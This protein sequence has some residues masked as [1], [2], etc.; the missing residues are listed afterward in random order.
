MFGIRVSVEPVDGDDD[1]DTV[2]SQVL[3]VSHQIG[4]SLLH[5]IDVFLKVLLA[6]GLARDHLRRFAAV[7]LQSAHRADQ[8]G[9]IRLQATVV[10]LDVEE[11]LATHIGTEASLGKHV[12]FLS[13]QLQSQLV[14]DDRGIAVRNVGEG[15]GVNQ[16]RSALQGLHSV[17]RQGVHHQHSQSSGDTE[18]IGCQGHSALGVTTN[19]A[20]QTISQI[21]QVGG[22]GQNSHDLGAHGDGEGGLPAQ[23]LRLPLGELA[24]TSTDLD[25][26]QVLVVAIGDSA[27]SDSVRV[28]IQENE[29]LDFLLGQRVRVAFLVSQA[30]LFQASI[31]RGFKRAFP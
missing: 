5:Q 17:G 19:H 29:L 22:Q 12:A 10:C 13:H 7:E 31:H 25:I 2:L 4:G 23:L 26:S 24:G 15:S 20:A 8:D 11:L 3:D 1:L 16:G 9:A 30:Q 14:G 21:L 27:P 6:Q 28:D 18:V